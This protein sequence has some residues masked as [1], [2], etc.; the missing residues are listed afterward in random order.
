G[1][2]LWPIEYDE[3]LPAGDLRDR[4]AV[5]GGLRAERVRIARR[6]TSQAAACQAR[7]RAVRAHARRDP[8]G[9]ALAFRGPAGR[10]GVRGLPPVATVWPALRP[11]D[12][13]EAP[14]ASDPSPHGALRP[15]TWLPAHQDR[16]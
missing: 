9:V 4:A 2:A 11:A 8:V 1:P 5:G 16:H 6:D 10:P 12:H 13:A 14:A 7:Q 3:R 15:R